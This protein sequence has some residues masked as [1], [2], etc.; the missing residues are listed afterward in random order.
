MN[1][2]PFDE[3]CKTR[4]HYPCVSFKHLQKVSDTLDNIVGALV[5]LE[6]SKVRNS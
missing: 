4:A 6:T 1:Q 2:A 5:G 3:P